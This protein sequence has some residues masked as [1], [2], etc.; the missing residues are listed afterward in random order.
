LQDPPRR[1]ALGRIGQRRMGPAGGSEALARLL[2]QRLLSPA[3][4]PNGMMA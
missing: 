2:E 1:S 3:A 4:G